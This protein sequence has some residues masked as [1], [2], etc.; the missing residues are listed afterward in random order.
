MTDLREVIAEALR[1][2]GEEFSRKVTVI[3]VFADGCAGL[4]V[5]EQDPVYIRVGQDVYSFCRHSAVD[6]ESSTADITTW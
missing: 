4:S 6:L 1:E 2:E 5:A 3:T